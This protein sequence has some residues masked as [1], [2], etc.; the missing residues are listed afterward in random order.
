MIF[1]PRILRAMGKALIYAGLICIVLGIILALTGVPVEAAAPLSAQVDTTYVYR[2]VLEDDDFLIVSRYYLIPADQVML[3]SFS[4]ITV[5]ANGDATDMVVT[6]RHTYADTTDLTVTINAGDVTACCRPLADLQTIQCTDIPSGTLAAGTY[7]AEIEY[8]GGWDAYSGNAVLYQLIDHDAAVDSQRTLPST[9][10]GV[11]ALYKAAGHG[12]TWADVDIAAKVVPSPS[13]WVDGISYS[14]APTFRATADQTATATQLDTDFRELLRLIEQG[15]AT[16]AASDYVTNDGITS[17]GRAVLE[18]AFSPVGVVIPD[19]FMPA[20]N[21][22]FHGFTPEPTSFVGAMDAATEA[23]GIVEAWKYHDSGIGR[24]TFGAIVIGISAIAT[25]V[26]MLVFTA[27]LTGAP[28]WP[29]A[30]IAVQFIF[31]MGWLIGAVSWQWA[32]ISAVLLLT[33]GLI[34]LVKDKVFA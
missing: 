1:N 34:W 5:D 24:W 30:L 8:L 4:G 21:N 27:R 18:A 12:I 15:D 25:A 23:E 17:A 13:L 3:D 6:N 10:Y 33:P 20:S 26:G 16:V 22:P 29:L 7:T 2:H 31:T 32:G 9:G 11:V 28:S 19:S 14:Q